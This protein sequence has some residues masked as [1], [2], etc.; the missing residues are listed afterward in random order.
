MQIILHV[1]INRPKNVG[2]LINFRLVSELNL[3]KKCQYLSKM[4]GAEVIFLK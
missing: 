4:H 1:H 2:E 3:K